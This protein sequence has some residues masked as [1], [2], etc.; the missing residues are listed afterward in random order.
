MLRLLALSSE[1]AAERESNPY[2]DH[3]SMANLLRSWHL[4]NPSSDDPSSLK[5]RT[6]LGHVGLYESGSG[7]RYPYQPIRWCSK[8]PG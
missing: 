7:L 1:A 3:G 2:L 6:L 8:Q 5:H 4:E